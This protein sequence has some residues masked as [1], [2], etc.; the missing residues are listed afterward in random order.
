MKK[1]TLWTSLF[2]WRIKNLLLTL[3][4]DSIIYTRTQESE[5]FKKLF[6]IFP[7]VHFYGFWYPFAKKRYIN[8][9]EL[10][11]ASTMMS[12]TVK[13]YFR[14]YFETVHCQK[15]CSPKTKYFAEIKWQKDV[16]R[17]NSYMIKLPKLYEIVNILHRINV[18]AICIV[19]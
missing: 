9:F 16:F 12:Q 15:C 7:I 14:W 3:V 5:D 1:I 10:L 19:K 4:W 2:H 8:A 18:F 17:R 11:W 13:D 6:L